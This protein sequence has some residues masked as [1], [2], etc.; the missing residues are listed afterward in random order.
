MSYAATL[1]SSL[2]QQWITEKHDSD[3]IREK[4]VGLG[5]EEDAI[6]SHIKEYKKQRHAKRLVTGFIC[7]GVGAFLGFVSCVLTIINPVPELYNWI[8]YGLTSIAISTIFV[9]LY[10]VFE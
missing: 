3:T 8:L 4:L 6:I 10:F 9:G 7:M 1:N 2:I 5:F